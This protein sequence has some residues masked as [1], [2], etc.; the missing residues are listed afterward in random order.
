M[1]AQ[2]VSWG[3]VLKAKRIADRTALAAVVAVVTTG[4]LPA[5]LTGALSVQMRRDLHFG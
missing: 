3:E 5:F 4:V 2:V 1:S